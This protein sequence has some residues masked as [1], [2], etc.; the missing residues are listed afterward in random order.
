MEESKGQDN[1][2]PEKL[3]AGKYRTPEDLETGYN[4]STRE[5]QRLKRE[6][7]QDHQVMMQMQNDLMNLKKSQTPDPIYE[8]LDELGLPGQAFDRLIE[9][10]ITSA[11]A[12]VLGDALKPF[13][14]SEKARGEVQEIYPDFNL[15]EARKAISK[16]PA[17]ADTYQSLLTTN[18]K[19]AYVMAHQA[20]L[21]GKFPQG[22]TESH[23]ETRTDAG[24]ARPKKVAETSDPT[25][26][27]TY[28][29]LLNHA[30]NTGDYSPFLRFRFDDSTSIGKL[31]QGD[32]DWSS[33]NF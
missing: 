13:A 2:T 11:V 7:E 33:N 5:Y 30:I 28:R 25:S 14:E 6:R 8:K 18:P 15:D 4:N 3:Y 1:P 22:K 10:K 29:D 21:A 26:E 19:A 32:N 31:S 24:M 17:L 16:D 23:K 27:Q 9:T 12:G 20:T